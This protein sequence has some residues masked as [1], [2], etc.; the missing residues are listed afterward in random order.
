ME[1]SI[2]GKYE[3]AAKSANVWGKESLKATKW[4]EAIVATTR[5]NSRKMLQ[6]DEKT[7]VRAKPLPGRMCFFQ[8]DPK[9]KKTLPYYDRYPLIVVVENV[10]KKHGGGV[11]GLNLH[12]L[13]PKMRAKLLFAM[14]DFI[15]NK[16]YNEATRFRLSYQLLKKA[17]KMKYFKPCFKH[18]LSEHIRSGVVQIEAE[19]WMTAIFLPTSKFVGATKETAWT[20]SKRTIRG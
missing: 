7:K 9:T 1:Q 17:S 14:N 11:Y 3:K 15:S 4:F 8:Y 10:P 6:F 16:K 20:D 5:G 18:Y 2:L 12:Y 19:D 13:P